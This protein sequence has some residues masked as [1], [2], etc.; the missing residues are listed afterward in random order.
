MLIYKRPIGSVTYLGGTPSL[1]ER[2]SWAFFQ[3][4]LYSNE[5]LCDS[6]TYINYDRSRCSAHSKARNELAQT[7]LGDWIIMVDADHEPPVDLIARMY[8]LFVKYKLDVLVGVYQIKVYPYPPLLYMWN[9]DHTEFELISS[10]ETEGEVFEIAAAGGGCLM[11]RRE[12]IWR[13][14]YELKE[15]PFDITFQRADKTGRPL[16]EDLSFFKRCSLLNIQ[17]YAAANIENPHLEIIQIT[18]KDNVKAKDA[19]MQSETR[20]AAAYFK[21]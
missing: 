4:A 19:G 8:N 21:K 10:F 14:L 7:M 20:E 2:F 18:M 15:L 1:L 11:I 5:Y 17:P 16:S 3:M 12:V 13:M 9:D 6:S